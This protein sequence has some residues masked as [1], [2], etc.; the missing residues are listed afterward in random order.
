MTTRIKSPQQLERLRDKARAEMDVRLGPKE[1][2]ITVHMGTSGIAAGA[3]EILTELIRQLSESS[4]ANVTLRQ[5]G[6]LGCCG[7]EPM[8]TLADK[9]GKEFLYGRLDRMKVR[10]IVQQHVIGGEPVRPYLVNV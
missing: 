7:Q 5:S 2:Q 1:I 8:I 4:L 10:E 6:G 9:S 3:R